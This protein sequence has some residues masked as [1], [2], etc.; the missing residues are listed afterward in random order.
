MASLCGVCICV[1]LNSFS[2]KNTRPREMLFVLKDTLSIKNEKV[3]KA[4]KSEIRSKIPPPPSP[5]PPR[6]WKF[7]HFT[8]VLSLTIEGIWMSPIL[9]TCTRQQ[10]DF[11]LWV[12]G[13]DLSYLF[14][15]NLLNNF[16]ALKFMKAC[17]KSINWKSISIGNWVISTLPLFSSYLMSK[18]LVSSKV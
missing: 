8:T 4:C 18:W 10:V 5:P 17:T 9:H 15:K 1:R 2:S 3:I 11:F 16:N 12:L 14:S 7:Q 6:V 13:L